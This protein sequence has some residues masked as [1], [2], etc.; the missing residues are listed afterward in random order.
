MKH[1][2]SSIT[3]MIVLFL[4]TGIGYGQEFSK[5]Q[6]MRKISTIQ[7]DWQGT[8]SLINLGKVKIHSY[9]SPENSAYVNTQ[10]IE[11]PNKIVV[12]D[13]QFLKPYASEVASYIKMLNKPIEKVL[14]SHSHPDHW[15]GHEAF[16]NATFY[17]LKSVKKELLEQGQA[18][19]DQNKPSLGD[20]IPNDNIASVETISVGK[21][22]IDGISFEYLELK[23]AEA[24]V[25]LTIKLSEFGVLIAQDL[26]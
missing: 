15:F 5:K 11:T 21:E 14:I 19:I 2:I 7:G 8:I 22:V 25:Q 17:T 1:K 23:E 18:I 24:S 3:I 13:M 20:M 4:N 6:M 9:M 10:I 16:S 26:V 12:I